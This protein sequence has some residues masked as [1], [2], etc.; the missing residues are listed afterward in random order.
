MAINVPIVSQFV[1]TGLDKAVREFKKLEGTGQKVGYA[2]QKAFLP[3]AAALG[4]LAAGAVVSAKA[5]A[6]D[7]AQQAELART[8]RA[9]TSATDAQ[10]A[11]NEDF[12]ATM[13]IATATA[14]GELRPALG[15]L[16]RATGDVT[17]AQEL[18]GLANDISAA[19]GKD[20]GAVSEALSK[21]YQGNTTALKRLDPSLTA[22]I[23][24]GADADEIFGELAKTF[25][26]A[27]ADAANTVEG[28]FAR[29]KIQMENTQETIGYAL[30]PILEKLLPTLER[31][32]TFVGNNTDLIIGIGVAVGTFATAIIAANIAMKAWATI[33][34]ITLAING[35]LATSFTA[36]WIATGIGI[37]VAIIAVIV[38]L[39]MKFNI[40]GKAVDG[41]KVAVKFLWEA[42]KIALGQIIDIINKLIDTWNKLPLVPDIERIDDAFLGLGKTTDNTAG[43]LDNAAAVAEHTAYEMAELRR[44]TGLAEQQMA[45]ALIPTVEKVGVSFNKATFELDA[46][47]GRLDRKEGMEK[48]N[49]QLDAIQEELSRLTPGT[50]EFISKFEEGQRLVGELSDEI[51]RIPAALELNLQLRGDLEL[52]QRVLNLSSMNDTYRA[53]GQDEQRF[54]SAGAFAAGT[55]ININ[56]PAGANGPDVVRALQNEANR[57]G[58]VQVVS[59]A[60]IRR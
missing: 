44:H 21:A 9:T 32:A 18:L 40:L 4:G 53:T 41:V 8:I 16:I 36:L 47:Y 24:A 56:M 50:A 2:L 39:Q 6:E 35:A 1:P 49:A 25:G 31:L 45:Q 19:T 55:T 5:A 3:A 60:G 59:N 15:N 57:S 43:K 14:D 17:K 12:I 46:F 52:L 22:I 33:N 11:A 26:G 10:I 23:G 28:R 37:I 42:A 34:S 58:S 54:L 30:L 7:A 13:E 48:F 29:M 27:A 51:K 20:L 38:T